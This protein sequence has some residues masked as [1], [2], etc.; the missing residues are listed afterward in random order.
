MVMKCTAAFMPLDAVLLFTDLFLSMKRKEPQPLAS[1]S[2]TFSPS[3]HQALSQV[4]Q[5]VYPSQQALLSSAGN[6]DTRLPPA[7]QR[8]QAY[9][10]LSQSDGGTYNYRRNS[11]DDDAAAAADAGQ[12]ESGRSSR[13]SSVGADVGVVDEDGR[14]ISSL[15]SAQQ[16]R[17]RVYV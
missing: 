9:A 12:R 17:M 11:R 15:L 1:S 14:F 8:P 4:P 2:D 16:A 13:G 5:R 10:A 3:S 7:D 6:G